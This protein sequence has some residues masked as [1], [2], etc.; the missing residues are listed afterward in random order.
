MSPD[1]PGPVLRFVL[2]API[3]LYDNDLGWLL[4]KRFLC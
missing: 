2:K 4:G 1:R 3:R